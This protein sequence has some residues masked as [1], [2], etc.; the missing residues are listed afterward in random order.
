MIWADGGEALQ[1]FGRGYPV[2]AALFEIGALGSTDMD[3]VYVVLI[4]A[5]TFKFLL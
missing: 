1:I 3:F 5:K 4:I 2:E